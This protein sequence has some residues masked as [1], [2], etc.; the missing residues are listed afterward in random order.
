MSRLTKFLR[1][2]CAYESAQRNAKGTTQTNDYG[3]ILYDAPVALRC[4]CEKLVMDIQTSS[5]AIV[6]TSSR[7]FL[8]DQVAV[9][10]DDRIDGHVILNVRDFTNQFG[11]CEGYECYV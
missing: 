3:E 11:K 2:K 4:R 1:Q 6:K 5:G 9:F 7:Y 10:A 8:D